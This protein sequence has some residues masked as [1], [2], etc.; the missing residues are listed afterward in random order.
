MGV[1]LEDLKEVERLVKNRDT[2]LI[3]A[4]FI[5]AKSRLQKHNELLN[6]VFGEGSDI[7]LIDAAI[8]N[9]KKKEAN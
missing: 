9:A 6:A 8:E 4:L 5:V 1:T 2:A 7:L 3:D